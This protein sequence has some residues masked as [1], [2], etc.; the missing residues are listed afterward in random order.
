MATHSSV[1]A[2][3][4]PGMGQPSGLPSMGS[5]RVGHNWSDLAAAA[6]STWPGGSRLQHSFHWPSSLFSLDWLIHLFIL[7][8]CVLEQVPVMPVCLSLDGSVFRELS[9][10]TPEP[11]FSLSRQDHLLS[12]A[13]MTPVINTP[14]FFMWGK[15]KGSDSQWTRWP[16]P[17][18]R[19]NEAG[20]L[21]NWRG[22][23]WNNWVSG[24]NVHLTRRVTVWSLVLL[25]NCL[26]P[27]KFFT[28]IKGVCWVCF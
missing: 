19:R 4:I 12:L 3:R 14:L 6:P 15:R 20:R 25:E 22:D 21:S 13:L 11:P 16:F 1:L 9:P 10:Q 23:N 27:S 18:A 26:V 2:W 7:C 8:F 17:P 24:R 28:G 5:H